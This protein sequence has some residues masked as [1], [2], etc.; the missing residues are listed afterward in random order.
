MIREALEGFQI[1]A[2][3]TEK[4]MQE[5]SRIQPTPP[6]GG[7]TLCA[8]GNCCLNPCPCF[9]GV[10]RKQS[11]LNTFQQPYNFA[12]PSEMTVELIDTPIALDLASNR[13]CGHKS[14]NLR[15]RVQVMDLRRMRIHRNTHPGF[16]PHNKESCPQRD[17]T[18]TTGFGG[19][20]NTDSRLSRLQRC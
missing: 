7:K 10:W 12:A 19:F 1:R 8:V 3:L 5:I 14:V 9:N 2:N 6:S 17:R 4:I 11:V 13:M 20:P 15:H 18:F 16:S